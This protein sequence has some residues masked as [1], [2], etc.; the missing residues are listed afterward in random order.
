MHNTPKKR[1]VAI[2]KHKAKVNNPIEKKFDANNNGFLDK[3][4]MKA[5][6]LAKIKHRKKFRLKRTKCETEV[7]R[8]LDAN[9]DGFLEEDELDGVEAELDRQY[10]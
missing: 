10:D 6:I 2:C 7:E 4:E 3:G 5:L 1:W 9:N 8:A